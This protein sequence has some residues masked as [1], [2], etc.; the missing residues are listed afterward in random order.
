MKKIA[1]LI[2]LTANIGFGQNFF[3]SEQD[4]YEESDTQSAYFSSSQEYGNVPDQGTDGAGNPGPQVPIDEWLFLLPLA[5]IILGV[6]YLSRNR[7][8]V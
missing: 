5:G 2:L 4:E 8:L 6:Y 7:E 3:E 1:L